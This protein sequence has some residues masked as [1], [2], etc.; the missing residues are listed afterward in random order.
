MARPEDFRS[1]PDIFISSTL[2]FPT[3][4]DLFEQQKGSFCYHYGADVCFIPTNLIALN[5]PIYITIY[6]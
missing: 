2:Q 3:V 6:I 5:Q 4:K 1:D